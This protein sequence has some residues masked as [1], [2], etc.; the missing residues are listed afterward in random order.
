MTDF[1]H[2]LR[3]YD[4]ET[5]WSNLGR[6]LSVACLP[7]FDRTQYFLRSQTITRLGQHEVGFTANQSPELSSQ[8]GDKLTTL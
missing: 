4:L 6:S 3:L 5:W 8:F 2:H 1:S 7:A